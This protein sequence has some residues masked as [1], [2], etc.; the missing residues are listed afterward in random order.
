MVDLVDDFEVARQQGLEHAHAPGL[1]RLGHQGVV[2]VG[3]RLAR[4]RPGFV[5]AQ[6]VLVQQQAHQLGR[7]QGRM[8]V[9]QMDGIELA[10][11]PQ[12]TELPQMASDQVLQRGADQ[13]GLLLQA[14]DAAGLGAVVGVEHPVQRV[15]GDAVFGRAGMVTLAE[16]REVDRIG[17]R[18]MPLAQG[19]DALAVVGR[20]DE[21]IAFG[22][23]AFGGQP[24]AC[25]PLLHEDP[26]AE[27]H[28]IAQLGTMDFPGVA[29]AHPV[30]RR[31]DLAATLDGLGKHAVL[32]AQAV[33]K[34]RQAYFSEGIQEA[35]RQTA[36]AAIAQGRVGLALQHIGQGL[37]LGQEGLAHR[38]V[39]AQCGQRVGQGPAHQ[40]LHRQ[41]VHPAH[42]RAGAAPGIGRLG[43]GP[44]LRQQFAACRGGGAQEH[45]GRGLPAAALR[46]LVEL[47]LDG[48]LECGLESVCLHGRGGRAV[49]KLSAGGHRGV[50]QCGARWPGQECRMSKK[51]KAQ[52]RR[53]PKYRLALAVCV[54]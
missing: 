6:A 41:I 50:H 22:D 24:A 43:R 37:T 32:V 13:E 39:Q 19:R 17:G 53:W 4:D 1:Q 23:Q 34:G 44:A 46:R 18:C 21:V 10:E 45:V 12:I 36:E 7:G 2:G 29:G 27:A 42:R 25:A 26:A 35:G 16:G 30:V 48:G 47:V 33:T 9:V 52:R 49:A 31:L 14:Q 40:K 3:D 11:S 20:H 51:S 38:L 5:P 15:G 28:R 8:G 54:V